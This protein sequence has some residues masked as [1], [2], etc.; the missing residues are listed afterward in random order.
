MKHTFSYGIIIA[1]MMVSSCGGKEPVNPLPGPDPTPV[2]VPDD[3]Q[4]GDPIVPDEN[5]QV[6][7]FIED[8]PASSVRAA[9]GIKVT[10]W[11][12]YTVY[13]GNKGYQV[14]LD[15]QN[16]PCFRLPWSQSGA[17]NVVLCTEAS[18]LYAGTSKYVGVKTPFSQF[19]HTMKEDVANLPAYASYSQVM[20][21]RMV[22]GTLCG[23]LDLCIK[24]TAKIASVKVE[25]PDRKLLAGIGNYSASLGAYT[26]SEGKDFVVLNTTAMGAFVQLD[27]SQ[28]T[29]FLVTLAAGEYPSGLD[30]TVCDEN[31]KMY[32]THLSSLKIEPGMAFGTMFT[33]SPDGDLL[34]YDGFDNFVWGG[35]YVG[36]NGTWGYSPTSEDVTINSGAALTGYEPALSPVKYSN[37]GAG[38]I[39]S[40]SQGEVS[41]KTVAISHQMSGAYVR[42]RNIGIYEYLFRVQEHPG[43]ISMGAGNNLGG[44]IQ[45][46]LT[47]LF[48]DNCDISFSFDIALAAGFKDNVLIDIMNSGMVKSV[49]VDGKSVQC[50]AS[51]SSYR[52]HSQKWAFERS[53][54]AI[55]ASPAEKKAWHHVEMILENI[56]NVSKILISTADGGTSGI[57][58]AYFDN[59]EVR[60]I[61]KALKGT[62]RVLYWN[63]QD[64]MWADQ[65]NDYQNFVNWVKRYNPDVCVWCESESIFK[66]KS[67]EYLASKDK[68]LPSGWP[69]LANRYGHTYT[70]QSGDRDNYSQMVTSKY[71]ITTL[72]KVTE[73]EDRSKPISHGA[74]L[75]QVTVGGRTVNI[76]SLHMWPQQYGYGVPA[77][78]A[79]L[80]EESAA[81]HEGDYYREYEM[82]WLCQNVYN[83]PAYSGQ[84]YWLVMGDTN[85]KSIVDNFYY[86]Q[87]ESD[88]Q[89]LC[90]NALYQTTDLVDIISD[91]YPGFYITSV[92]SEKARIDIMYA[93][94]KM[95]ECVSRA[96]ILTDDW[97]TLNR[98][99]YVTSYF[100]MPS[101]HSP[102]LVDFTY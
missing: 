65:H 29:H 88:T 73:T 86:K 85:A 60:K 97:C 45:A 84:P 12:A 36:G 27:P 1:L 21:N 11:S 40:N 99:P 75:Y 87:S 51:L 93:S 62:L 10:D 39:Q 89:F 42:S 91:R 32:R 70:A 94:P 63:V 72:L 68:Y 82:R 8:A 14:E 98:C 96:Q 5:G 77:S 28:G 31:H 100:G 83:N 9:A 101:D 30:I 7:F 54:V 92:L 3:P 35:D 46:P 49:T 38:F 19:H 17:Y 80:R 52:I 2:P 13:S 76:M 6:L 53:S 57:H 66:D 55:P 69:V 58:G 22:F 18:S 90:H 78:P 47:E 4:P 44:M 41:G 81:R 33:Y 50:D 16:R 64:G 59:L 56:N 74:G 34:F 43:Y 37:P 95:N 15:K 102:V 71:P 26:L 23:A 24:G 79:N 61:N 67:E 20:G 25:N 48:T